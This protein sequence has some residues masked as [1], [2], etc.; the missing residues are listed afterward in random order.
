MTTAQI[1]QLQTSLGVP[2]TG[3]F[4]SATSAA[5]NAAVS[6][7]LSSN[8]DAQAYAGANTTD[9]ILNAYQTGD[10]S[11]VTSLSGQPFTADQQQAAVAQ[12]NT[13][14][15]PAYDASVSKDTADTAASLEANQS[16]LSQY[17]RDQASQF[18]KDKNALDQNAADSGVLFSG[19][20][21]QKQN[22]LRTT[23][24][25][26]DADARAKAAAAAASTA[27]GFQYQY[28]NDAVKP[29]ASLYT[30]PGAPTYNANVA[31]G[32]VTTSP[33]ISTMYDPS[34][35]NFQG[36]APAAQSAAVQTRS[37]GL[38]ANKANKL[39]LSGVG[40]KL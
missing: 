2:A 15:A 22:D 24:A 30:A 7:S 4:D 3:V 11:A 32:K 28:G 1:Q 5:Y 39:S 38:L 18:G 26:A 25:N 8:P 33:R 21:V 10:W 27:R 29:L 37:A 36:T 19:A 13:A 35:Y 40:T 12:A 14:L 17:E 31:G 6:K 9:A 23:Y 34:A 16:G 20:R